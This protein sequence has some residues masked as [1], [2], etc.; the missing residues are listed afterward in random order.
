MKQISYLKKIVGYLS[1]VLLLGIALNACNT[2]PGSPEKERKRMGSSRP[3]KIIYILNAL[4]PSMEEFSKLGGVLSDAFKSEGLS[5]E[6][7]ALIT[8]SRATSEKNI[9]QQASEALEKI[10]RQVGEENHEIILIGHSQGGLR[11]AKI[12]FLNEQEGRRL[13]IKGL[14]TLG[15]PWEGAPAAGITKTSVQSFLQ[16]RTVSYAL[17]GATYLYPTTG[18]LTNGSIDNLFD[19]Y[20]PTHEPGVEDMVPNSEFLQELANDLASNV[21]PILAIAGDNGNVK[22]YI[23]YSEVETQAYASYLKSIPPGCLNLA[24][25]SVFAGGCWVKHDMVV[26]LCSQLAQNIT[27]NYTFETYVI[28]G[29]VHDFLPGLSIPSDQVIYN[30]VEAI[31]RIVEFA[32]LNF[33]FKRRKDTCCVS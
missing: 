27:K 18:Q 4:W 8:P 29:A 16:K 25:A 30:H 28:R 19:Q 24:Y 31:E 26:P 6:V 13:N 1:S 32:E 33:S 22:E 5:I 21:T 17:A 12:L 10:K 14:V 23:D 15:T 9:T 20:F 7:R 2:P 11:G 3:K